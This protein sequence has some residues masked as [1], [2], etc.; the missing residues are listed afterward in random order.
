M[1]NNNIIETT[2]DSEI[3]M[4]VTETAELNAM[5]KLITC[6]TEIFNMVN[7]LDYDY[8]GAMNMFYKTKREKYG[9]RFIRHIER[10]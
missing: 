7:A 4:I 5:N 9:F 2:H 10:I 3:S 6:W 8:K 1:L